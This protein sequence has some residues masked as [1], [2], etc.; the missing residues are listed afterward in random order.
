[1]D[2]TL[3]KVTSLVYARSRTNILAFR[4]VGGQRRLRLFAVGD[5]L[6]GKEVYLCDLRGPQP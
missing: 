6:F 3:C 1:M 4:E 2:I 5:H